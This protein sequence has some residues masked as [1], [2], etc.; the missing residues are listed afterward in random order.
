M[1]EKGREVKS[2][3]CERLLDERVVLRAIDC[4]DNRVTQPEKSEGN[5]PDVVSRSTM[6]NQTA[7]KP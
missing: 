1:R 3:K 7:Y 6:F 4:V 2:S 5:F